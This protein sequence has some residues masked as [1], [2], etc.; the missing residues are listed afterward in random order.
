MTGHGMRTM[1]HEEWRP[2]PGLEGIYEVSNCGRVKSLSRRDSR[3]H[4]RK[5][6]VL[7]L[8]SQD[9]G[10]L[11]VGLYR[12]G[13]TRQKT[14]PIHRLVLE[15]FVGSCPEGMEGCHNDG[16]PTNN[17]VGNL[18]WDTRKEN[19]K[20]KVRHGNHPMK[21]RTHCPRGHLLEEPNLCSYEKSRGYRQCLACTKVYGRTKKVAKKDFQEVSD[22]YYLK[23][24]ETKRVTI[25]TPYQG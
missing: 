19:Q 22:Q 17:H 15:A 20:D 13:S 6:K 25:L 11:V 14:Y 4:L 23:I 2:V 1:K 21:N 18:R 5:E 9:S 12:P 3:G 24:M 10:H 16:N 7:K 8:D